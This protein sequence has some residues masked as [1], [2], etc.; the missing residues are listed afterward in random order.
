[1]KAIH[2]LLVMALSSVVSGCTKKEELPECLGSCTIVAGRL[3]TSGSAALANT[4]VVLEWH[5]RFNGL[6]SKVR[7]KA[8]GTTDANGYYR[9]SA[10][11]A[12]DELTDGYLSVVFQANPSRYYLIGEPNVAFFDYKR[13]TLLTAYDYI[14]PRKAFIRFEVTNPSQIP[15]PYS[16][17]ADL[18]SCHGGN[19]VFSS[20]IRGG[21]VVVNCSGLSTTPIE[22]AGDQPILVRQR[23]NGSYVAPNDTIFIPAG[24]TLTYRLTY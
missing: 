17:H 4:P 14:I 24:T 18:N 1:M 15:G 10:F 5:G 20:S 11:L 23:K 22:T 2:L 16:Y 3:L 8:V 13:D 6:N 19:T 7:K 9:I 21:G 12:D